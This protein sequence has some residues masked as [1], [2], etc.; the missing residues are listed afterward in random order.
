MKNILLPIVERSNISG[1]YP[2]IDIFLLFKYKFLDVSNGFI[3]FVFHNIEISGDIELIFPL[4]NPLPE[5]CT[6]LLSGTLPTFYNTSNNIL[7]RDCIVKYIKDNVITSCWWDIIRSNIGNNLFHFSPNRVF[8]VS[9]LMN[10]HYTISNVMYPTEVAGNVY[11]YFNA[12]NSE[13]NLVLSVNMLYNGCPLDGDTA[14]FSMYIDSI[15]IRIKCSSCGFSN[16]YLEI[17]TWEMER[18]LTDCIKRKI[19]IQ[20][21]DNILINLIL[22]VFASNARR[23]LMLNIM[24]LA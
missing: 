3:R 24:D 9:E 16:E 21:Y 22:S 20:Q 19:E 11:E 13:N 6:V 1:A 2:I 7:D 17:S 10:L 15:I 14:H 18:L 8:S 4:T 5:N 23:R 12:I